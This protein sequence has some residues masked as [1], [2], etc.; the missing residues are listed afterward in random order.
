VEK[1]INDERVVYGRRTVQEYLRGSDPGDLKKLILCRTNQKN[2]NEELSFLAGKK[3]LHAEFL[4]TD[5]FNSHARK[6]QFTQGV[7]LYVKKRTLTEDHVTDYLMKAQK[8]DLVVMLDHIEDVMN[9]GSILRT[10]GFYGVRLVVT[11][12][13]RAA[14][15]TPAVEKVASGALAL[16]PVAEVTNLTNTLREFKKK[17]YWVAG[18]ALGDKSQELRD[19]DF[20][21]RTLLVIGNEHKGMSRLVMENCDFLLKITGGGKIQSLNA[22]VSAA[23]FID[24]FYCAEKRKGRET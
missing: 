17:D 24:R 8:R 11:P 4:D 9:F 13:D 16:V 23:V 3:G 18:T 7:L 15:I 22:G 20:P 1:N 6:Y 5:A 12:R 2:I 21:D 10:C 14:E 19:F